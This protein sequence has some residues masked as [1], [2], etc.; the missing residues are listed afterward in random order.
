MEIVQ[1]PDF[2]TGGIIC[3]RSGI[4]RGYHT[5]R[6]TIV[7]RGKATIEETQGPQPHRRHRDPVQQQRDRVEERIAAL[8][9]D[10]RIKGISG[11]RDESDLKEPVRLVIDLKRDADPDVVLEPA[12]PV[13]AA[14]GHVLASSCWRWSTAS[15]ACCRS[16]SMLEEFIRHRVDGDS[17]PDAVP[18]GPGPQAQA[19][20]R[21]PAAGAGQHRR[22]HRDHSR[23]ADA[24]RSQ[25]S[26]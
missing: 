16:R 13:L 1:G 3:G 25:S 10:G 12:L 14:A 17:P 22:D 6:S 20:R 8:V 24:G 5:G 15:R 4:R 23:L 26:G 11:I 19:H 7:V 2:P 21:R 9:N 18:A